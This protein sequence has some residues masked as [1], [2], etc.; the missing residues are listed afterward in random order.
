MKKILCG[1]RFEPDKYITIHVQNISSMISSN[2]DAKAS[3]L[4]EKNYKQN[5]LITGNN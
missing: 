5:F 2:S 4:V 3:E 1:Q